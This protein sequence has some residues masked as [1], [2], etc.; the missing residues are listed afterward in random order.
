MAKSGGLAA[1]D[2]AGASNHGHDAFLSE[3]ARS[4][5][6][7]KKRL[8]A[9]VCAGLIGWSGSASVSLQACAHR[10]RALGKNVVVA[11][12]LEVFHIY[13]M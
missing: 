13:G 8:A 7:I 11:M 4:A 6:Q 9:P 1:A 2:D 3:F 12:A 5:R 10:Y